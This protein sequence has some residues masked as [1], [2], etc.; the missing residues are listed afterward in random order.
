MKTQCSQKN[1]RQDHIGKNRDNKLFFKKEMQ[2]YRSTLGPTELNRLVE[3]LGIC[4]LQALEV[5]IL[6]ASKNICFS[7]LE[8]TF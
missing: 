7:E 2:M 1:K 6:H 3:G 4:I 8:A 5:I